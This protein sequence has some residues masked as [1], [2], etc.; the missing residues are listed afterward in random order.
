MQ[1][2]IKDGSQTSKDKE[3][4][5][6]NLESIEE[7]A[8]P[9]RPV[10]RRSGLRRSRGHATSYEAVQNNQLKRKPFYCIYCVGSLY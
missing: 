10:L 3:V 2:I 9:T 6:N 5:R 7:T 4:T 8:L 1:L